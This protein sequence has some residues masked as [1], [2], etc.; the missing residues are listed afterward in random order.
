[1]L[2]KIRKLRHK[3]PQQTVSKHQNGERARE[4]ATAAPDQEPVYSSDQPIRSKEQ[5]RFNRWPF[6]QRIAETLAGRTDPSSLVIGIYGP[7]GDGKSSTLYLMEEGLGQ[8][9]DVVRVRFNPWHFDSEDQLLRGFF[10]T[11]GDAIG[12]SLSSKGEEI[13]RILKQYGSLLS[14]ASVSI[15]GA[16]QLG[17]GDA[18]KGLGEALSNVTLDEL[19]GCL[20]ALLREQGKRIT[21]LI[22]DIDRLDRREIQAIFRLIKLS[23]SF[24]YTSYVLAFDDKMVAAAL[25]ERYGEG[26]V[27]AGRAFLEKIVQ[28]P[29]HLP[30][31]DELSL[32]KVTFEGVETALRLSGITLSEEQAEAF[33]RHFVD[34]LEPRLTTPRQSK[35]FVNVL[36]FSLPILKGE[37]Y[38]VD[39]MLIEGIRVF[40]PKLYVTIRDNPEYFLRLDRDGRD[41]RIRQ[42]ATELIESAL[43]GTGIMDAGMVKR[44]L[45]EML[46]PR[47]KNTVY[48]SEWDERWSREQRACSMDYFARY[49]SYSVPLGDVPDLKVNQ[50]LKIAG[51]AEDADIDHM[52]KELGASNRM[53]RLI[54]KLGF[55]E[56]S[57]ESQA[58]AR[59]ALAFC[60]NG[61]LLPREKQMLLSDWSFSEAAIL[62]TKLIRRLA[63]EKERDEL[64]RQV[65][66]EAQPLAFAFE[67]LK[68]LRKDK[69]Q[70]ETERVL[71]VEVEEELADMLV[72][73]IRSQATQAPLYKSQGTDAPR[74]FWIWNKYAPSG[75]V[76]SYLREHFEADPAEIDHFLAV[77]VGKASGMEGGLS[78]VADFERNNVDAVAALVA[79][80]FVLAKLKERYGSEL[81]APQ[82]Y[83]SDDVP[84]GR[85]IAHQFAFV[86]L[87]ITK[88][89]EKKAESQSAN[90]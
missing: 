53:T 42:R 50:L 20:E 75:E 13:G 70:A 17:A 41:D 73:R 11:L 26:N 52:L 64:A 66:K 1:M 6:A 7:W 24:D 18:A 5:D 87:G 29:L 46:F 23:A 90:A 16:F 61:S 78:H 14:V 81:D 51:S 3:A 74:L 68:W 55:R 71:A 59:L 89:Q 48:G 8:H 88:Q 9:P 38:P 2:S 40:Y 32:R 44:R 76:E 39:Q 67:C 35:L 63:S 36:Q 69:D 19:R 25:G 33:V 65:I 83:H 21:I 27:E 85:R 22:D 34:G 45:L 80:E 47:L 12:K 43:E 54:Q 37:V 82:E 10:A 57:V 77:Y 49:F 72:E 79:P 60:R 86:Y 28:V 31:A 15:A 58:A 4:G 30:P 56:D 62:V 84:I